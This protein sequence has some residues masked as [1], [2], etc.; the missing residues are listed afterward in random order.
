VLLVPLASCAVIAP[1]SAVSPIHS[2]VPPHPCAADDFPDLIH[3]FTLHEKDG[4]Y[5]GPNYEWFKL[6]RVAPDAVSA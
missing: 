4:A 1:D 6:Q 5:E 2:T 3:Y